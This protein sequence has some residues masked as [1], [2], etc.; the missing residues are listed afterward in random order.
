MLLLGVDTTTPAKSKWNW[1]AAG[2]AA[3]GAMQ[4]AGQYWNAAQPQTRTGTPVFS[5]GTYNQFLS[6]IPELAAIQPSEYQLA[7]YR[8]AM[9]GIKGALGPTDIS[10]MKGTYGKLSNLQGEIYD[11]F[12]QATAGLQTYGKQL[13]NQTTAADIAAGRQDVERRKTLAMRPGVNAAQREAILSQ[14]G[15]ADAEARYGGR[16][17]EYGQNVRDVAGSQQT[18]GQAFL[19]GIS[20]AA[21]LAAQ[22]AGIRA[23]DAMRVIQGNAELAKLAMTDPQQ[24]AQ[25]AIAQIKSGLLNMATGSTTTQK[26]GGDKF[27]KVMAA[28]SVAVPIIIAI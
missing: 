26:Q 14:A 6:N 23:S 12:R 8:G 19:S 11:P 9:E 18:M 16:L 20:K 28:A 17:S 27:N 24:A 7:N 22:M 5:Q 4:A 2:Q 25:I 21:D 15:Q 1:N 13:A 3:P 10:E